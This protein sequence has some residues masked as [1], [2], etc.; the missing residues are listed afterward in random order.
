MSR[1]PKP[2]PGQ[3]PAVVWTERGPRPFLAAFAGA[4]ALAAVLLTLAE[5]DLTWTANP[6]VWA[7]VAVIAAIVALVAWSRIATIAAGKD[8][9][10]AGSSWV[11]TSKLTRVKFAPSPRPTLHLEDSAGRDLTLDLLALAA[12]PTLSTHLTTTIRT[13]TPDL[14]LDPQTTDY[15]NSL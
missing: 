9:F 4:V 1:R 5:G 6:L 7:V 8:W 14:P 15:L 2:P 11:R 12:H 3:G 13:N 10:R